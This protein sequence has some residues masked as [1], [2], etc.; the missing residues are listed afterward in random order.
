MLSS[1]YICIVLFLRCSYVHWFG[2][3][4]ARTRVYNKMHT[5]I[6]ASTRYPIFES[7]ELLPSRYY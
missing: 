7:K 5:A 2:I 1:C 3:Y 6:L 4:P